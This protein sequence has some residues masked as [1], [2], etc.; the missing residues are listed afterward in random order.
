MSLKPSHLDDF[1]G[2]TREQARLLRD[3]QF[4]RLDVDAIAEELELAGRRDLLA[5]RETA[6]Q[7]L[8]ML[9]R[10]MCWPHIGTE[11]ILYIGANE[12]RH[13]AATLFSPSMR[14]GIDIQE[15]YEQA[16]RWLPAQVEGQPP[17]P[18][19]EKCPVTLDE[20]IA[21]TGDE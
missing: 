3:R 1:Y 4:E 7:A 5:F 8:S 13:G 21:L 2:W 19:P 12:L 14:A 15:I 16:K 18:L 20:L 10:A 17:L 9:L 11:S 6:A